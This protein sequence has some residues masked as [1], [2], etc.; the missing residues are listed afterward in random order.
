MVVPLLLR[1]D[2]LLSNGLLQYCVVCHVNR[3]A[4]TDG[5]HLRH[6]AFLSD[7]KL[8]DLV[9][10]DSRLHVLLV[11]G[12]RREKRRIQILNTQYG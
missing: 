12:R 10:L 1:L 11:V 6:S 7:R 2:A 9:V 8:R 3:V 5:F 4:L